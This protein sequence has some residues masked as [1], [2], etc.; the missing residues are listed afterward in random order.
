MSSNG[1][2]T[3]ELQCQ[4]GINE[5]KRKKKAQAAR[6]IRK[7][8]KKIDLRSTQVKTLRV[9]SYDVEA[10]ASSSDANALGSLL[11]VNR[12]RFFPT[13]RVIKRRRMNKRLAEALG[14]CF[15]TCQD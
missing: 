5:G 1:L 14:L 10:K 12:E 9:I 6:R 7:P 4:E 11:Y 2:P 8:K 13:P 15:R 3:D